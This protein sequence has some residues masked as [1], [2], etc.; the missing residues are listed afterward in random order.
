MSGK[1]SNTT[2]HNNKT[3]LFPIPEKLCI[4]VSLKFLPRC[5]RRTW[6]AWR[7]VVANKGICRNFAQKCFL[8]LDFND[9]IIRFF[10][11]W[12]F[13]HRN[14]TGERVALVVFKYSVYD[15]QRS[16][17]YLLGDLFDM[18]QPGK[19]LCWA[20]WNFP[21]RNKTHF[22]LSFFKR[23]RLALNLVKISP[24][25]SRSTLLTPPT[26]WS[27]AL[28]F[29]VTDKKTKNIEIIVFMLIGKKLR[30]GQFSTCV[31]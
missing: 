1:I 14:L 20:D 4:H 11:P 18:N 29:M 21:K 10:H 17:N 23:W 5:S 6:V 28:V 9:Q 13:P 26:I 15:V 19:I 31:W 22:K 7:C 2:A 3:I 8:F 12:S 25:L 27:W 16:R 30:R 24:A